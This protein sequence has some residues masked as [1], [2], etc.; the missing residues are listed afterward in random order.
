MRRFDE[1]TVHNPYGDR[2]AALDDPRTDADR[3]RQVVEELVVWEAEETAHGFRHV[4]IVH[5]DPVDVVSSRRLSAF[6]DTLHTLTAGAV[7][8]RVR[9]TAEYLTVT[10]RGADAD[11][12]VAQI[13]ARARGVDPG[14][15]VS[16]TAF[17]LAV[18]A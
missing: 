14:W 10:V 1:P 16:P 3:C 5:G 6:Y 15:E 12:R 4:T 8:V 9:G 13:A 18:T 17:P 7:W 2:L 11:D